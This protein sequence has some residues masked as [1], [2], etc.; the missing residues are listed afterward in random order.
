METTFLIGNGFD[1]CMGMNTRYKDFYEFYSKLPT[2]NLSPSLKTFREAIAD[3][4][5][6][7]MKCDKNEI[8]WSDLEFALG[9]YSAELTASEQFINIVLDVNRE[10]SE[11]I[12]EQDRQFQIDEGVAAHLYKDFCNPDRQPFL[13]YVDSQSF[14]NF[15]RGL[16]SENIHIVNFNY[17][18]TIEKIRN[19]Y[20]SK[21]VL[22]NSG[23]YAAEVKDIIH[24]HSQIGVDKA[25]LVGVNDPSQIAN[26]KFRTNQDVL[27]VVV[28]P[29]SNKMFGNGKSSQVKHLLNSSQ[30]VVLFGLSLGETDKLW[31]EY[32]GSLLVKQRIRLLYF[33]Y[34]NPAE[35]EPL[36]LGKRSRDF[37]KKFCDAAGIPEEQRSTV[38]SLIYISYNT[39]LFT[40]PESPKG[41]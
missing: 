8:D 14:A 41:I 33:A 22:G 7:G 30:L 40:I 11:Y 24:I 34:D 29:E 9:Q 18:N 17:T 2:N 12:G 32:I 19:A 10:L 20:K 23:G 31:W 28:K 25:I 4:V 27:D 16:G 13:S 21:T 6:K 1:V 5:C 35:E 37:R 3:Y 36:R 26:D 39:P 38:D 15:K